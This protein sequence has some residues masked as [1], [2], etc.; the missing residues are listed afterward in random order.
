[1]APYGTPVKR[2]TF[3]P[4]APNVVTDAL[5]NRENYLHTGE[6]DPLVQF[7][8]LKAQFELIYPFRYGN[9]KDR[10]YAGSNHPLQQAFPVHADVLQQCVT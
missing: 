1:M 7:S 5:T 8:V 2:A 9:K 6:K 10:V 4:P 3:I